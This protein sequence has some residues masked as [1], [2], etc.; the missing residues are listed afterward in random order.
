MNTAKWPFAIDEDGL[1]VY[2]DVA[3]PKFLDSAQVRLRACSGGAPGMCM[4]EASMRHGCCMP[5]LSSG[6]EGEYICTSV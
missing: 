4:L 3:L 5:L 1:N 2:V 6:D